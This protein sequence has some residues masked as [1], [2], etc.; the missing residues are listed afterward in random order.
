MT[1]YQYERPPTAAVESPQSPSVRH[2]DTLEH[3]VKR[4]SD[5]VDQQAE[6]LRE[7]QRI[8]RRLQNELRAA[9]NSFNLK[10]HG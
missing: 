2:S 3:H 5:R 9:V 10:S 1:Q 6:D 7:M 4:L 8:V